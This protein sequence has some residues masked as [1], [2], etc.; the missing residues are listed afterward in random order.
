MSS[1]VKFQNY[2]IFWLNHSSLSGETKTRKFLS[3]NFSQCNFEKLIQI[4]PTSSAY[5]Y[6]HKKG[7]LM[8][9]S[10]LMVSSLICKY[11][12]ETSETCQVIYLLE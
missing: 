1:N 7:Y 11:K 2:K 8:T 12:N 6:T 3:H 10:K 9:M 4:L 5:N